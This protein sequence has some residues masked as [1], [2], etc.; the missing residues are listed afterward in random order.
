MIY[1]DYANDLVLLKNTS[2]QAES[3]LHI[4]EQAAKSMSLNINV[5]KTLFMCFRQDRA[6]SA[7]KGKALILVDHFLYLSNNISS[8]ENDVNIHSRMA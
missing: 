5:D 8:I 3:L 4:L 6:I 7:S 1:A 2:A